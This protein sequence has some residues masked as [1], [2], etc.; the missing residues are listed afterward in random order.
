MKT[1]LSPTPS[2]LAQA[3]RQLPQANAGVAAGLVDGRAQVLAQRRVQAMADHSPQARQSQAMQTLAD[4]SPQTRQLQALSTSM[5]TRQTAARPAISPQQLA[6]VMQARQGRL[7][8][9]F[10]MKALAP[11]NPIAAGTAGAMQLK[12]DASKLNIAGENH[13]E[14]E[15]EIGRQE[16]NKFTSAKAGSANYWTEYEFEV[17]EVGPTGA[18]VKTPADPPLT[19][20]LYLL[21]VTRKRLAELKTYIAINDGS[22][23]CYSGWETWC[24]SL[25]QGIETLNSHID[26]CV[27]SKELD[28]STDV[29]TCVKSTTQLLA[30]I[31]PKPSVAEMAPYAELAAKY[32]A[33]AAPLA[34][35]LGGS[36]DQ[37]ADEESSN[38]TRNA[39]M[40]AAGNKMFATK[41]VWKVGDAHVT[42][43]K[44]MNAPEYKYNLVTRAEFLAELKDYQAE[45]AKKKDSCVI[46]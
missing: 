2:P 33:A 26:R 29:K 1:Q 41:G 44:A 20:I 35:T 22:A 32:E 15:E 23:G 37:Y 9:V 42:D 11:V 12:L 18:V 8:P 24:K 13:T 21:S 46:S 28:N 40:H 38:T 17:R 39:A 3:T 4:H 43:I 10:Q 14:S 45:E 6:G 19:L 36:G 34:L 16:E 30:I 5:Q 25:K 31:K 27:E 7:K